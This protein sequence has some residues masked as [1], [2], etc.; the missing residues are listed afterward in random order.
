MEDSPRILAL[1]YGERR[2][3]FA[4]SDPTG[5]IALPLSVE[6]VKSEKEALDA[7]AAKCRETGCARL[8]VGLP[9]NM[10]GSSGFMV[11]RVHAFIGK[12]KETISIP[13]ETYDERLT[14]RMAERS[15]I[16]GDLSRKK[17]KGLRDKVA[18]QIFLQS[19]MDA[20]GWKLKD[21]ETLQ[22]GSIL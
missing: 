18:A 19:Y 13:V 6:H 3:G 16:D 9:V 20:Q 2:L 12:L 11:E 22:D 21:N 17:R 7:V 14:S 1:D 4:V 8:V 10:N 15:L 5:Q